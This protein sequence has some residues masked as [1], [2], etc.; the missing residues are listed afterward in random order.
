MIID[1]SQLSWR[2]SSYSQEGGNSCVEVAAPVPTTGLFVRDS[3]VTDG[4]VL[5]F[6]AAAWAA[7]RTSVQASGW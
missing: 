6:E 1:Q 3:K 2:K 7:F 5:K 4:P